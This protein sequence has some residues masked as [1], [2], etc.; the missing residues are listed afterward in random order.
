VRRLFSRE[1]AVLTLAV[2]SLA[3]TAAASAY[4]MASSPGAAAVCVPHQGS[5]RYEA[6]RCDSGDRG[7]SWNARSPAGPGP[8]SQP[9]PRSLPGDHGAVAGLLV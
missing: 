9:D 5:G 4:V 6:Q 1:A 2:L 7:L 8:R 3:V